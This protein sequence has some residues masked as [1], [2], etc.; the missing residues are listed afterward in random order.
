MLFT[1]F[2]FALGGYLV[3]T[4]YAF[5]KE[6]DRKTRN[7]VLMVLFYVIGGLLMVGTVSSLFFAN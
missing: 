7:T 2:F 4:A 5:Q 6:K 1:I 3:S